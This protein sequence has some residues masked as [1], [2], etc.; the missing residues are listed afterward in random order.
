MAHS[1]AR[2]LAPAGQYRVVVLRRAAAALTTAGYRTEEQDFKN[3]LRHKEPP[4]E[5]TIP[6]DADG[7]AEFVAALTRLWPAF[8]SARLLKSAV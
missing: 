1:G 4:P 3:A 6:V 8:D 7:V 2:P 5:H